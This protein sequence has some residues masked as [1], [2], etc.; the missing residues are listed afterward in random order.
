MA[1]PEV[2]CNADEIVLYNVSSRLILLGATATESPTSWEWTILDVP[3]GSTANV[4]VKGDFTDGI[5]VIQNPQLEIDGAIDGTY[6]V[7][8]VATNAI[9]ESSNPFKDKGNGQQCIVVRSQRKQ[10][11]FPGD[12]QYGY[13]GEYLDKTLRNLE[14]V[15][16]T[17][18][19]NGGDDEISVDGLS[20]LLADSQTPLS[21]KA[22]HQDGGGDELDV[23]DL[24]GLLAD[25]QTPLSHKASHQDG[26]GDELDVTDLSGLLADPQTPLSHKASHQDGGG[27]EINVEGLA[28]VLTDAQIPQSHASDHGSGGVDEI[29][30]DDLGAP[31]DNTDL[32]ATISAHGLLKKLSGNVLDRLDGQGNWTPNIKDNLTATTNP[33]TG[34]DS[35]DG[36]SVRSFWI[37]TDT[38]T[39][40]ICNDATVGSAVW[41][42]IEA[43]IA[44][45]LGGSQHTI[46]S[47][48]NLNAK[49]SGGDLDFSTASRPPSGSAGGQLGGMYPD[50]DV[51]GIRE[52]SGP[53]ELTIGDIA[54]GEYLKRDG[55]N[56]V[57][58]DP[59]PVMHVE[60]FLSTGETSFVLTYQ[61]LVADTPCGYSLQ[62]LMNGL[63]ARHVAGTPTVMDTFHYENSTRTVTFISDTGSYYK[64]RYNVTSSGN[65]VTYLSSGVPNLVEESFS[66]TGGETPGD[67]VSFALT[68]TPS[69]NGAAS[70]PSGYNISGVFRNSTRLGYNN[71]P[72]SV[73]EY[74]YD[75]VSNEIDI[76]AGGTADDYDIVFIDTF[77]VSPHVKEY[78]TTGGE[79]PGD[80]VSFAL[81]EVPNGGGVAD[82]PSGYDLK[83]FVDGVRMK[84]K[85]PA[86][87]ATNEFYYDSA[88]NEVD[89]YASGNID[90]Y[91][92]DFG[93]A[94]I[95]YSGDLVKYKFEDDFDDNSIHPRWT[96][97]ETGSGTVV[98]GSDGIVMTLPGSAGH[99]AS[100]DLLLP[101]EMNKANWVA[102]VHVTF[103]FTGSSDDA[104]AAFLRLTGKG[105]GADKYM[106]MFI[107]GQSGPV[108]QLKIDDNAGFVSQS[109]V[110]A[111]WIR[112]RKF[113]D[114]VR[115][116]F[117]NG[118]ATVDVDGNAYWQEW[119]SSKTWYVLPKSGTFNYPVKL[120][121]LSLYASNWSNYPGVQATFRKFKLEI[122]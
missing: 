28:G 75:P 71:P 121:Q 36:Y 88:N 96:V 76:Y 91:V 38:D 44:H 95:D 20:G 120:E 85:S 94:S 90:D 47:L 4:G 23:T 25:P 26:G 83:G 62:V 82:T 52:T 1:K 16:S 34:D 41:Q 92:F 113:G 40:F 105:G 5:A 12:S 13:G 18:H 37:N 11:Y 80:I 101:N 106:R 65:D 57:S 74:Y 102:Q 58:D 17:T 7:Q 86:P 89:V 119:D 107:Q 61:P 14:E 35:D 66:T 116:D 48:A 30:L 109:G 67:I 81:P 24:S 118:A 77:A 33:T 32:N 10:N 70:T 69:G 54:D 64:F 21:H 45:A 53:T 51:R 29:K 50:P 3:A 112:L 111:V 99:G 79:T 87:T 46:D 97:T 59:L 60:T 63:E 117:Y 49:I 6:V 68:G 78:V 84:Y 93:T 114:E 72:T 55:S 9:P 27:D 108:Y 43:D 56:I 42:E 31:D 73:F 98:E 19:E 115:T 39:A 122:F 15:H 100:I 8:C 104:A 110:T 2:T 103:A 22:S